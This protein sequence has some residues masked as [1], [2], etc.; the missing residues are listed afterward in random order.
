MQSCQYALANIS[1]ADA[2]IPILFSFGGYTVEQLLIIE[3]FIVAAVH[4]IADTQLGLELKIA[5][6]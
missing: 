1:D 4:N 2:R 3:R 6:G 5:G